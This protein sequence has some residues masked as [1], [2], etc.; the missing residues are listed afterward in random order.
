MGRTLW[1]VSHTEPPPPPPA[2]LCAPSSASVDVHVTLSAL[3]GAEAT[4]P[5]VPRRRLPWPRSGHLGPSWWPLPLDWRGCTRNNPWLARLGHTPPAFPSAPLAGMHTQQS[6][7]GK[8]GA[9]PSSLPLRPTVN[10]ETHRPLAS[11]CLWARGWHQ[12]GYLGLLGLCAFSRSLIFFSRFPT[13]SRVFFSF[14][15]VC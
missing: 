9:Y 15:G 4:S 12:V 8:I 5:G 14:P 11:L 6:M 7:V 1:C 3:D 13:F 10:R 2:G